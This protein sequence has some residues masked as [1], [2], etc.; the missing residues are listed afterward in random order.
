MWKGGKRKVERS[1]REIEE[2]NE[3]D[4]I[5]LFIVSNFPTKAPFRIVF[6]ATTQ[7]T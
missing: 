1:K 5:Q 4:V 2:E 3:R 7:L 6:A